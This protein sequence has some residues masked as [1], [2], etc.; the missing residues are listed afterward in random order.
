MPR[1]LFGAAIIVVLSACGDARPTEAHR[2]VLDRVPSALLTGRIAFDRWFF[3]LGDDPIAALY[4]MHL[5]AGVT[6]KVL[7][8]TPGEC[9]TDPSWSPDGTT[10]AYRAYCGAVAIVPGELFIGNVATNVI[11][12]ITFND[13]K[14][15][16][17][18]WSP[19]GA[20]L[21]F[22]RTVDGNHEIFVRNIASLTDTRITHTPQI[23][24]NP[25]WSPG[26]NR[27]AFQRRYGASWSIVIRD[28]TTGQETV[29]NHDA[30]ASDEHPAWSPDGN[31]IAFARTQTDPVGV[32]NVLV[33]DL[34]TNTV[35]DSIVAPGAESPA[36]SPAGDALVF[37]EQA[38]HGRKLQLDLFV[39]TLASKTKVRLTNTSIGERNP[40]WTQ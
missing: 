33:Y 8:Q 11:Q 34:A 5:T 32:D 12:Q 27:I 3:G 31:T 29:I 13:V 1:A 22:V 20:A 28:L 38:Y 2:P 35:V 36:W 24:L 6:T 30:T 18:A 16:H 15:M 17:P 14:D 37:S 9:E 23:E 26:G 7:S 21:A 10:I 39:V 40:S 4:V 19:S 25:A